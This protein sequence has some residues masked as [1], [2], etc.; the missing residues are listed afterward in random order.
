MLPPVVLRIWNIGIFLI[1]HLATLFWDFSDCFLHHALRNSSLGYPYDPARPHQPGLHLILKPLLSDCRVGPW[2]PSLHFKGES[3]VLTW[4][5][6]FVIS[7]AEFSPTPLYL[8]SSLH[9]HPRSLRAGTAFLLSYL[10]F[11]P[12]AQCP[13]Y[14]IWLINV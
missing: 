12:S 8:A 1:S 2:T 14:S 5:H 3:S 4:L 6:Y 7:L 9:S 10:Y 11:Q 13:A